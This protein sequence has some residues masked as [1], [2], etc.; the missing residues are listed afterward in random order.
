MPYSMLPAAK[1]YK[2]AA[3]I[4]E[5]AMSFIQPYGCQFDRQTVTQLDIQSDRHIDRQTVSQ[6]V[7]QSQ[8]DS[9]TDK[10][11]FI[12][13]VSHTDSWTDIVRW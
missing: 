10:H 11:T 9:Q 12:Q 7:R 3:R 2:R 5:Q 4:D 8:L 13:T 1:N 6:T